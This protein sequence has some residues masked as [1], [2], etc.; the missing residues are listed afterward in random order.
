MFNDSDFQRLS[1]W[2][3]YRKG[4]KEIPVDSIVSVGYTIGTYRGA[5]GPVLSSNIRFVILLSVPRSL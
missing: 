1:T 5:T 2:P 3:L 4:T